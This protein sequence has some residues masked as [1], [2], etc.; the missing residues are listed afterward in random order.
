MNNK[1]KMLRKWLAITLCFAI[2]AFAIP[3]MM[4]NDFFA[5]DSGPLVIVLD[6]GHGGSDVGAVNYEAGLYESELN[7]AIALAC[8][9]QLAQY[10]DVEVYMTHEGIAYSDGVLSLG[11][12]VALAGRV[13][14]DIL[15]SLHCNDSSN[16]AASGSEV[17]VSHS[18]YK[19]SYYQDSVE[20]ALCILDNF[21][22]LGMNIRGV[23][24]RLSNG[25]R[26]YHHE[27]GS[28]EIGDYYAVI[29]STIKNYGIPG[30]L[31]EH[32]FVKGD[33]AFLSNYDN[34]RAL[35]VADA[36]AIA[37]YYKLRL[38]SEVE[39]EEE[40]IEQAEVIVT[41]DADIISAS[42]VTNRLMSMP[43]QPT[44]EDYELLQEIRKAYERLSYPAKTL[45]SVDDVDRLYHSILAVDELVYPVRLNTAE[46]SELNVNRINHTVIGVKAENGGVRGMTAAELRTQMTYEYIS[47]AGTV[48]TPVI[49][50]VDSEGNSM[51][52]GAQ[53]GTGTQIQLWADGNLLDVLAVVIPFDVSGDGRV[54]SLDRYVLEEYVYQDEVL[55]EARLAA[56]DAN[57]DRT[58]N[59][60]DV[61]AIIDVLLKQ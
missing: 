23:K 26:V 4:N 2:V 56:A 32:A 55:S 17:Y 33:S 37:T 11:D 9:D 19:Q 54:D 41:T 29:G 43:A 59:D 22:G 42:D 47:G 50:I 46:Q 51:D 14:A 10:A 12:R 28:Q 8:R 36:D 27:D 15:I 58:I 45:V 39:E 49:V 40:N 20:L 3:M 21:R 31:V 34:L 60:V 48:E 24:T 5:K 38:K 7:L 18:T 35:G 6:P 16:A 57:G 44:A 25:Q 61:E 52:I 53:V 13:N 30:I 1:N